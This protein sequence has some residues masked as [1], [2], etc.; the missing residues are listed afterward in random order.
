[1]S[2]PTEPFFLLL[3]DSYT[4]PVPLVVYHHGNGETE[5]A[6]HTDTRKTTTTAALL[7]A[8]YAVV[9]SNA[10]GNNWGNRAGQNDYVQLIRFLKT[11][12]GVSRVLFLSQSMGGCTGLTLASKIQVQI[13]GWAGIYPVCDLDAMYALPEYEPGIQTAYNIN[14]DDSNYAIKTAGHNPVDL[15]PELFTGLRM[16]FYASYDDTVTPRAL[17]TDPFQALVAPYATES[18]IVACTG[19]H[20]DASHFQ[21]ADLVAF[22]D[23]CV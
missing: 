7:A 15:D 3:P 21:T 18:T 23:R 11:A 8:G 5:S 19:D 10:S 12:I 13:K 6:I 16:R 9:G 2:V 4:P 17:H 22:F 14:T 1:M 20:G